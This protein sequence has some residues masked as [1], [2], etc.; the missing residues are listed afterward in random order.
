MS[1]PL[2]GIVVS[3]LTELNIVIVQLLVLLLKMQQIDEKEA[4]VGLY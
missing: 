4:Q 2:Q 3:E 1:G